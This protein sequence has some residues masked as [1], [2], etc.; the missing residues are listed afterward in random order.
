[1]SNSLFNRQKNQFIIVH[2]LY[3]NKLQSIEKSCSSGG[4]SKSKYYRLRKIFLNKKNDKHKKNNSDYG[5]SY[6]PDNRSSIT[7]KVK[8]NDLTKDTEIELCKSDGT[9]L[10]TAQNN[11]P[12]SSKKKQKG[13]N[14]DNKPFILDPN[15]KPVHLCSSNEIDKRF[16]DIFRNEGLYK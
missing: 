16:N 8:K 10:F 5:S 14:N 9:P 2:D 1:M 4:I 7:K 3:V 15:R 12:K 13:G 11:I 6:G